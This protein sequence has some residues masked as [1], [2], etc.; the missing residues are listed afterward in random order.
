MTLFSRF[1]GAG[2]IRTSA[3]DHLDPMI[4]ERPI[5][6]E[7]KGA[8]KVSRLSRGMSC[9]SKAQ[10]PVIE[11]TDIANVTLIGNQTD[12]FRGGILRFGQSTMTSREDGHRGLFRRRASL[13][14]AQMDLGPQLFALLGARQI[15]GK[16]DTSHL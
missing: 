3:T 7:Q 16:L 10:A 4:A 6:V 2:R 11:T 8:N 1:G 15:A 9:P 5:G 14:I 12:L 13:L